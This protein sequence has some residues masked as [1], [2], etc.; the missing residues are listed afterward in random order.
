MQPRAQA[1]RSA[2]WL[3]AVLVLAAPVAASASNPSVEVEYVAPMGDFE[4][5]EYVY[6]EGAL[7]GEVVRPDKSTGTYV[8]PILVIYPASGSNGIGVVDWVN[9]AGYGRLDADGNPVVCERGEE[10]CEEGEVAG[11]RNLRFASQYGRDLTEDYLFNN[12]YTY[13]AV[14]WAKVVTDAMGPEPID[15]TLRRRLGY[16]AIEQPADSREIVIDIADYLRDPS[17]LDGLEIP[18]FPAHDRIIG[19]AFST[20]AALQRHFM[21]AG[22]NVR[23]SGLVYDGFANIVP[24]SMC[25]TFE[26]Q[27]QDIAVCPGPP[28]TGDAKVLSIGTQSDLEFFAGF[29]GRDLQNMAPNFRSWELA[30]VAHLPSP[31]F[32]MTFLGTKTQNPIS[33]RPVARALF[34]HLRAWMEDG[35]EPPPSVFI[36]GTANDMGMW[37]TTLDADGNAVGGVRLPHM[38]RV[39][40]NGDTVG[41]PTGT[42]FGLNFDELMSPQVNPVIVLGGGYTPFDA[43]EL[44]SRYP[45]K[46][47]YQ[48]L[49]TAS[50]DQLLADGYILEIDRDWYASGR[51]DTPT[52]PVIPE[53][54]D[55]EPEDDSDGCAAAGAG[56]GSTAGTLV[57]L[58]L[59][60]VGAR[61]RRAAG[62]S[63]LRASAPLALLVALT[64]AT[65]A[66]SSEDGDDDDDGDGACT[67]H[68]CVQAPINLP[69][70]GE[71]RLELVAID[72]GPLEVRTHAWFASEQSPGSRKWP[73]PPADWSVQDGP[74]VCGDLR[75]GD[76]WPVGDPESRT[77]RDAGDSVEFSTSDGVI[78]LN[79]EENVQDWANDNYH[80]ILYV[81]DVPAVD[82]APGTEYDF[83]VAGSDDFPAQTFERAIRMPETD[84]VTFPNMDDQVLIPRNEDFVFEWD[85]S[86]DDPFDFAFVMVSDFIGPVSFCI[87]PQSGF[88]TIPKEVIAGLPQS[89][90]LLHALVNHRVQEVD[91]RRVD[92]IGVNCVLGDYI[93][94]PAP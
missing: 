11:H 56:S 73:R 69:E 18:T 57:L 89:G 44:T 59:V 93:V 82:I 31:I 13:V 50:A 64:A 54:P 51:A 21:A 14:Q 28:V 76:T 86:S 80:D 85:S 46:E 55:P 42:Y 4:G 36:D 9:N 52:P 84:N 88:M 38:T 65:T 75:D 91:G 43:E 23:E 78:A 70:G 49:V 16:G 48:E 33:F 3:C 22:T 24:G 53:P 8:A 68:A 26:G 39:L 12:G 92:F 60:L 37:T 7:R 19:F 20:S 5:R 77:Y 30:G 87:G 17:A 74:T 66:C 6:F 10:L 83:T 67:G 25:V 1:R 58:A 94:D 34:H 41:A 32:D 45:D 90:L 29:F 81:A 27:G 63:P 47:A 71:V 15:G 61:R 79:R 2:G 72:D 40:D 35:T 62:R